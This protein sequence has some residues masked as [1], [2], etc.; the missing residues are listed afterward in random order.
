VDRVHG[1]VDRGR[2]R[3]HGGPGGSASDALPA[4]NAPGVAGLGGSPV[5]VGDEDGEE[6]KPVTGSPGHGQRRRRTVVARARRTSG[7]G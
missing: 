5:A 7:G 4:H 6:V 3:V 1:A 2:G